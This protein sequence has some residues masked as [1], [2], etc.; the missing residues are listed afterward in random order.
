MSEF[1][2]Q[3]DDALKLKNFINRLT[4]LSL[5]Q[6]HSWWAKPSLVTIT[7]AWLNFFDLLFCMDLSSWQNRKCEI[8]Q[9]WLWLAIVNYSFFEYTIG[10]IEGPH[11]VNVRSSVIIFQMHF[12]K[13]SARFTITVKMR[14]TL[15]NLRFNRC[16]LRSTR[17]TVP[18]G[19]SSSWLLWTYI[20][21]RI[22]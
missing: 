2:K 17:A 6:Y 18:T 1:F 10:K 12:S 14:H 3:N 8:V 13:P 4:H 16:K 21:T 11:F 20:W 9:H 19:R 15:F 22:V 7:K 5:F